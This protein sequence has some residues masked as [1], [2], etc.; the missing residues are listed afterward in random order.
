MYIFPDHTAQDIATHN[1]DKLQ[2]FPVGVNK[3]TGALEQALWPIDFTVG[4]T[5]HLHGWL[6]PENKPPVEVFHRITRIALCEFYVERITWKVEHRTDPD[7]KQYGLIPIED[8]RIT[9]GRWAA[10]RFLRL[11]FGEHERVG[12]EIYTS[13]L[14]SFI[15][16]FV[17]GNAPGRQPL[18]SE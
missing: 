9:S 3:E 5:I 4:Q 1:T 14:K 10:P 13:V 2:F 8:I 18:T 12:V 6:H 11:Y 7:L 16:C 17:T 15:G